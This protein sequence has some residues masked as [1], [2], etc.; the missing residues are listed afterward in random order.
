MS[1]T[2]QLSLFGS[3]MPVLLG[4]NSDTLGVIALIPRLVFLGKCISVPVVDGSDGS[5]VW[6]VRAPC[7]LIIRTEPFDPLHRSYR[8]RAEQTSEHRTTTTGRPL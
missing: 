8:V 7:P 4:S 3:E 1:S 6:K 5:S 2:G